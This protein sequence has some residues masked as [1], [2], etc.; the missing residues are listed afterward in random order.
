MVRAASAEED[1]SRCQSRAGT[2]G[3]AVQSADKGSMKART[4]DQAPPY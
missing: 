1:L 4:V 3:V 2:F